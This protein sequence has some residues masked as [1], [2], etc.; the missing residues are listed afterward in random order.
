MQPGQRRDRVD[1]RDILLEAAIE[2]FAARGFAGASTTSIAKRADA[3]QPQINYHFSS[4]A[5]LWEAAVDLLFAELDEALGHID[6][7]IDPVSGFELLVRR[8]VRFSA[9]RPQLNKI[10]V[11]EAMSPTQRLAWVTERHVRHRYDG[12]VRV[13]Q[14]L[15]ALGVAAPIDPRLVH[16]VLV[17]A[18]SLPFINQSELG[19]LLGDDPLDESVIEAHIQGVVATFM[20]G[21][22]A[23]QSPARSRAIASGRIE[24]CED[25]ALPDP[26]DLHL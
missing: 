7:S 18:T 12:L 20:P 10:L 19:A 2:E 16:H 6:Y 26:T 25:R 24:Q 8:L 1:I 5:A 21:H 22:L 3:H 17:G 23:V 15:Q 9:N 13:W 4:K 14:S 11:Q